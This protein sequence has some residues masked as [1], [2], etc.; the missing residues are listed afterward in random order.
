M[1]REFRLSI[2]FR[3]FSGLLLSVLI[4]FFL[5]L[6]L[7]GLNVPGKHGLSALLFCFV[8]VI[9]CVLMLIN[10]FRSRVTVSD[11]SITRTTAFGTKELLCVDVKGCRV[12]EKVIY[13]DPLEGAASPKIT[14]NN[15]QD[16]KDSDELKKWISEK[17]TDLYGVSLSA[18]KQ[19]FLQNKKYGLTK[20]ERKNK[21]KKGKKIALI[22]NV[23]GFVLLFAMIP[24]NNRPVA[25]LIM[26]GYPLLGVT[27]IVAGRGVTRFLSSGKVSV[28]PFVGFGITMPI[29][30]M[31]FK[32]L[33]QFNIYSYTN[34][35]FPCLGIGA[36]LFTILYRWGTN[37]S[38]P[39]KTAQALIMLL[40]SGLYGFGTTM[41]LNCAFDSSTPKQYKT[42]VLDKTI[43][44]GKSTTYTLALKA[45]QPH[46]TAKSI[47]VD[48]GTY[49]ATQIGDTVNVSIRKG[50]LHIPW[51]Y[52]IN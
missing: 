17:F 24:V 15:Y 33:N 1:E 16:F 8:V 46:G 20:A 52:L 49:H 4:L 48:R 43:K 45:W 35:W 5:G 38:L 7:S 51:F 28:Y 30:I 47:D 13:I 39:S 44:R 31:L 27:I 14:I 21:L 50:L 9:P 11:Y 2:G 22:Y 37:S 36:M 40:I 42:T 29:F 10:V 26:M 19:K 34:T 23:A 3:I 6:G 41:Q 25:A 18:E 32:S 12:G